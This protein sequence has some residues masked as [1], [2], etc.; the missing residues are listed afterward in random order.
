MTDR[1]LGI[2]VD[3][4]PGGWVA[5]CAFGAAAGGS[6]TA[7]RSEPRF[8]ASIDEL[9]A[10]RSAQ[11]G[12][13]DAPVAVDIPIGLPEVVR[14]RACDDVARRRMPGPRK[15]SVFHAPPRYLLQRAAGPVDGKPPGARVVFA[16]VQDAI[17]EQQ[18][19]ADAAAAEAGV[20]AET[21]LKLSQQGTA[22][23]VK[24]AEVDAF[25]RAPQPTGAPD[26]QQWLFEV[27]PEMCFRALNGGAVPPSKTTALGQLQRLDVVRREFPDAEERIRAWAGAARHSLLDV[28]DAYAACWTAL[29]WAL[30][31]AGAP[32]RRAGVTPALEV[33]GEDADGRSPMEQATG[34]LMRMVV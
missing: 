3:G 6:P 22:I 14:Y 10:W 23:L 12:G 21:L 31:G 4:A 29:R 5:A 17:A 24:V 15:G 19:A 1:L 9:A 8:F 2:G 16:R 13:E 34:L 26:R 32:E 33:L 18:R 30:T 7:R 28:L 11:L 27:H 20:A 25:L